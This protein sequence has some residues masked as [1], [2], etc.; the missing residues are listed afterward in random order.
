MP[1]P[2]YPAKIAAVRFSAKVLI[3]SS[4]VVVDDPY[5]QTGRIGSRHAGR[6]ARPGGLRDQLARTAPRADMDAVAANRYPAGVVQGRN[7]AESMRRRARRGEPALRSVRERRGWGR[8][9][10][11]ARGD[12]RG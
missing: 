10:G 4:K 6:K 11:R 12:G 3:T 5:R 8:V 7:D 2:T 1:L 9:A